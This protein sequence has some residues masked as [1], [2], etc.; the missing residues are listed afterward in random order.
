MCNES[1]LRKIKKA[2]ELADRAGTPAEGQV[3][4]SMAQELMLKYSVSADDL[5]DEQAEIVTIYFDENSKRLNKFVKR[6]AVTLRKHF[7]IEI[8]VT[9]TRTGN[10]LSIIGRRYDAQNFKIMLAS[11]ITQH[12]RLYLAQ[13]KLH[14]INNPSASLAEMR[15]I[16]DSYCRGFIEG[17]DEAFTANETEKGLIVVTPTDITDYVE[18]TS[19][20]KGATL[21]MGSYGK[22]YSQGKADGKQTGSASKATKVEIEFS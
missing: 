17:V 12:N 21:N 22:G 13:Y 3:A 11:I 4:L 8:M 6:F 1:I 19:T 5:T 15:G 16:R 9:T 2:L 18:S 10:K 7:P 20:K 14:K